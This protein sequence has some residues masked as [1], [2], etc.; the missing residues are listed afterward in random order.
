MVE[1]HKLASAKPMLWLE[2][3]YTACSPHLKSLPAGLGPQLP[4]C[5]VVAAAV[6][7]EAAEALLPT[8]LGRCSC[9]RLLLHCI[10][11]GPIRALIIICGRQLLLHASAAA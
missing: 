11:T 6:L 7:W 2:H 5:A 10:V 3:L 4:C 1:R 9:R 8:A